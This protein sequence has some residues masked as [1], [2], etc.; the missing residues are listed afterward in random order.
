MRWFI[1]LIYLGKELIDLGF[2]GSF[3]RITYEILNRSGARRYLKPV[4]PCHSVSKNAYLGEVP[5]CL[6]RFRKE[7]KY[8][9][10]PQYA[11]M[12]KGIKKVPQIPSE[13]IMQ[14]ALKAEKGQIKCFSH[15]YADFGDPINWHL[16]PIRGVS[17]PANEHF[18]RILG[19]EKQCGDCK[20]TWEINRFPHIYTW[21]RAYILTGDSR[22]V[23]A[24]MNQLKEW[25]NSNPYRSGLNWNSGQELAI[26]SLSWIAGLYLFLEDENF[27][28]ED[29]QRLLRLLYLHGAHIY[30]NISYARLAV[31]NNHLIG[32]A[33]ALYI[34][35]SLFPWMHGAGKWKRKG[36][37]LLEKDCIHQ[38]YDDGGYCQSSHN[39]HRL[40]LHYYLWACRAG[41]CLG[42]PFGQGVYR[43]L[44][45]SLYYLLS[46]INRLDGRLPNWGANDGALLC[47]WISCDYS[48]FRPVLTA[49]S[50][51]TT[52]KRLFGNG[53][54]D[55]ELLWFW[56]IDALT[57]PVKA[58][59]Y[60]SISC[61]NHSGLY[62]LRQ[63]LNDF[64]VFRCGSL[65]DR[66]GQADQLH[67]DIWWQGLNVA[68][69]GGSYLYNDELP[70]HHHFMGTASHNTITI[71]EK[72]Q[73]LL[74]RRFKWLDWVKAGNVA[75][76]EDETRLEV[77]G[78]HYGYCRLPGKVMHRRRFISINDGV[79]VTIDYL[80]PKK[81]INHKYDLH[82]LLGPWPYKMIKHQQWWRVL[83][84]T[85]VGG[86]NLDIC[87]LFN[88]YKPFKGEY[89]T[90]IT[91]KADKPP[92]GWESRFYG[93]RQA[94]TSVK[95]SCTTKDNICF[96]SIFS[97]SQ[98]NASVTIKNNLL[99]GIFNDSK[100]C[101]T[102]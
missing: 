96:L 15:W 64:A 61:F 81:L 31:H 74:I 51:L 55:E 12:A 48:D 65:R 83:Q 17:W 80:T 22:W 24:W 32:E 43:T 68:R 76:N 50:Y 63:G 33:L 52:G 9:F 57:K 21:L 100:W 47:P 28:E 4:K 39:Y 93:K 46:F 13:K 29:F 69:D 37:S 20:L 36:R 56:G 92:R 6:Q 2:K 44:Y 45:K 66:F 94:V 62:C 8:F 102:L 42:E 23:K 86:Y 82:W 27:L 75:T 73:M 54:W 49:V 90:I 72:N 99:E 70:Y 59:Q 60:K 18:S 88:D 34:L 78:E 11:E 58:P 98:A 85:P 19:F 97:P 77:S 41:E 101:I 30:A 38:F 67:L 16:N 79:Y 7:K 25:E 10:I 3:F 35:G 40:A 5:M 87:V 71:D 84:E 91:G 26:R 14:E 95:V 1:K 53:P 89:C